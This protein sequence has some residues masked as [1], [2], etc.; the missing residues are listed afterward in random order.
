MK[1]TKIFVTVFLL[2][3]CLNSTQAM[4]YN[5]NIDSLTK[6]LFVKSESLAIKKRIQYSKHYDF[7]EEN[8]VGEQFIK[9]VLKESPELINNTNYYKWGLLRLLSDKTIERDFYTDLDIIAILYNLCID[10][11]IDIVDSVFIKVK[12]R[13]LSIEIMKNLIVQ[14]PYLTITLAKNYRCHQVYEKLYQIRKELQLIN[15]NN[16][17]SNIITQ[18]IDS[19][20]SG[21]TWKIIPERLKK[22]NLYKNLKNNAPSCK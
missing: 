15:M 14:N 8:Y 7:L 5:I 9:T 12:S 22:R 18:E 11:Y 2:F 21:N 20:I 1:K 17:I 3:L 4:N 6:K 10:D 19:I 13:D 16:Q